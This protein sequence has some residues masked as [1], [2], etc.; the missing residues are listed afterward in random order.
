[1]LDRG[2][3]R[4]KLLEY[5]DLSR[6]RTSPNVAKTTPREEFLLLVPGV[7][8]AVLW[9]AMFA[10]FL[11][12]VSEI[13]KLEWICLFIWLFFMNRVNVPTSGYEKPL[14]CSC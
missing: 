4:K 13:L 11:A 9:F 5:Q 12:L 2:C 10:S 7:D 3:F 8:Q 14:G 1:M 6:G